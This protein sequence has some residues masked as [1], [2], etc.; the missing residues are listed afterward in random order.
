MKP[1]QINRR[2]LLQTSAI[3]AGTAAALSSTSHSSIAASSNLKIKAADIVLFQGDSIT[4][5]RRDRRTEAQANHPG[6]LGNGYPFMIA[7]G[8]LLDHSKLGLKV[9]NR[10]ISGHKVPDLQK[11]WQKDTLDLKPAVLSILVGGERYL[12]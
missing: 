12:A 5:A 1:N 8:L 2:Q 11:R 3:A 10:G 6:A 7:S 9:Y 4:D